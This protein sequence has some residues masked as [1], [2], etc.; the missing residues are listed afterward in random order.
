[1]G[2]DRPSPD[3]NVINSSACFVQSISETPPRCLYSYM[4]CQFQCNRPALLCFASVTRHNNLLVPDILVGAGAVSD[5]KFRPTVWYICS[6]ILNLLLLRSYVLDPPLTPCIVLLNAL[7]VVNHL[8]P[9]LFCSRNRT[10][11]LTVGK[12]LC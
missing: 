8:P 7:F 2:P 5:L 3:H 12:A 9:F 4:L 11:R 6:F 10:C 1:V